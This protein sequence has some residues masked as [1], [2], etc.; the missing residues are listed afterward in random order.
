MIVRVPLTGNK[1]VEDSRLGLSSFLVHLRCRRGQTSI[2]PHKKGLEQSLILG[3]HWLGRGI[4]TVG[5][6][7]ASDS[8]VAAVGRLLWRIGNLEKRIQFRLTPCLFVLFFLDAALFFLLLSFFF[9]PL[10]GFEAILLF[11]LFAFLLPLF[12]AGDFFFF[13]SSFF[14][15]SLGSLFLALFFLLG[16]F[17]FFS[18]FFF[19]RETFPL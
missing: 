17:L 12:G 15:G 5:L 7:R 6:D 8:R 14:G 1:L 16:L 11:L 10:L 3:L 19:S 9:V 18:D 2:F 4:T 13:L